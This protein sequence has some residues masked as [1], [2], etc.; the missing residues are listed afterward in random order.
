MKNIKNLIYILFSVSVFTSCML[1]D[2]ESIPPN[3]VKVAQGGVT[4]QD[5]STVIEY[6]T[7]R[8][9]KDS[10]TR[11]YTLTNSSNQMLRFSAI[12][13]DNQDFFVKL[14][15]DTLALFPRETLNFSVTFSP[16][17]GGETIGKISFSTNDPA[18]PVFSFGVKGEGITPPEIVGNNSPQFDSLNGVPLGFGEPNGTLFTV[19]IYIEDTYDRIDPSQLSVELQAIFSNG[20]RP[21]P[22][23]KN[24]SQI[25]LSEDKTRLSYSFAV[26]FG[27]SSFVDVETKL[28]LGNGDISNAF[29]TRIERPGGAN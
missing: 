19:E 28:I 10:V 17:L 1:T 9:I 20:D 11:N 23:I 29:K 8:V 2:L 24:P 12:T 13:S 16:Q 4:I 22:V 27:Q 26:R 18:F 7:L 25:T 14:E 6:G 15:R 3:S 21:A 5:Q